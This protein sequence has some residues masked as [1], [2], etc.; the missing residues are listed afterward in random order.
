MLKIPF[1]QLT[2]NGVDLKALAQDINHP[3]N[4]VPTPAFYDAYYAKVNASPDLIGQDWKERKQKN[5]SHWLKTQL[6]AYAGKSAKSISIGAGF[7]LIE[8]P[9]IEDGYQIELYDF[10]SSSFDHLCM[11]DKT[12]CHSGSWDDLPDSTYDICFTMATTYAFDEPTFK[13]FAAMAQ[14]ILKPGGVC[15]IM[16]T[17][18]GWQEI[19]GQLRN[20]KNYEKNYMLWGY[21][22]SLARWASSF[23]RF[24]VLE[25]R[26]YARGM[27]EINVRTF[28]GVPYNTVPHRQYMAL[29]KKG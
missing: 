8:L 29:K 23:K 27:N 13:D 25:Q 7:G 9:L 18:I 28:L 21:K 14:R 24:E 19:Y 16:D 1:Y 20:F 17:S 10:Q 12:T 26:Y 15:M 2:W 5:Q 3:T 22:R 11:Q 6:D 4:Q